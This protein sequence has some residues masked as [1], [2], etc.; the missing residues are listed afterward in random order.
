MHCEIGIPVMAYAEFIN[1][2]EPTHNKTNNNRFILS[3]IITNYR[4][5]QFRHLAQFADTLCTQ[6]LAQTPKSDEYNIGLLSRSGHMMCN[7]EY[8]RHR[9]WIP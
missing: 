8:N 1:C 7:I 4:S 5:P 2:I 3:P 9:R 6:T